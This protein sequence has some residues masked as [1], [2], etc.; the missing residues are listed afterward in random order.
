MLK[1][2][3]LNLNI[4]RYRGPQFDSGRKD[5]ST[6]LDFKVWSKNIAIAETRSDEL[7]LTRIYEG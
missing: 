2:V 5:F 1:A 7:K 3:K 6:C 4:V